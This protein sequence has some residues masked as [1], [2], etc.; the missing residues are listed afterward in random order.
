LVARFPSFGE[1]ALTAARLSRKCNQITRKPA[2]LPN[3]M[4][5][6]PIASRKG[7]DDSW[8]LVRYWADAHAR[9]VRST[10]PKSGVLASIEL[11]DLQIADSGEGCTRRHTAGCTWSFTLT[12]P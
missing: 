1:P 7:N 8:W 12:L 10:T 9:K 6:S 4:H 2:L 11:M 3:S 5:K